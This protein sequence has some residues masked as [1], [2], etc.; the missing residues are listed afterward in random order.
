MSERET[1]DRR[2]G[3]QPEPAVLSSARWRA[4]TPR[5]PARR[6]SGCNGRFHPPVITSAAAASADS[7]STVVLYG[8][9]LCPYCQRLRRVMLRLREA[10]GDRLVY[11]FR[12]FPN[13]RAHPGGR[14]HRP[15]H[16]GGGEAGPFWEMHDWIYDSDDADRPRRGASNTRARSASTWRDSRRTSRARRPRA[17]VEEDLAGG[18]RNGVTGTPTL[19]IDGVRYDGAWDFYSMLE[20]LERPVAARL[21]RSARVFASLPASGGLVLLLS[22]PASRSCAPTRRSRGA[23]TALMYAPIQH[24]PSRA[25]SVLDRRG[26]VLGRAADALLPARRPRDPPRRHGRSAHRPTGGHVCRSSPPW[27]ASS[28]PPPSIWPSI[29][30]RARPGWSIPTATDIAFTLGILALLGDRSPPQLARLRRRPRRHRRHPLGAD[31]SRSSIRTTSTSPGWRP[32]RLA[33]ALLFTFNRWRVYATWPYVTVSIALWLALHAAGVDAA[34]T[35]VHPGPACLPTRPAPTASAFSAQAATALAAL[36]HAETEARAS[37]ATSRHSS[38]F[39]FGTGR[40]AT[41]RGERA[42]ALARRSVRARRRSLEHLRGA[43]RSSPFPPSAYRSPRSLTAR[44][45]SGPRR[46]GVRARAGQ[47]AWYSVAAWLAVR[48]RLA[49]CP[50]RCHADSVSSARPFFAAWGTRVALLIADRAF[51]GD[52]VAS[53]AKIGVL[54]GS[55][56]AGGLGSLILIIAS[57]RPAKSRDPQ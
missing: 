16:R 5:Q 53:L 27:A 32:A 4:T 51:P 57:R 6:R 18:Q 30:G 46:R 12:H 45:V 41:S 37:A 10:L 33:V 43:S 15:R 21:A 56:L 29:A 55:L 40:A 24:R 54:L 47:A 48:T 50:G 28:R 42:A 2:P 36:E 13:E 49:M 31:A 23:T 52:E 19:F 20:A 8:D 14:A 44:S 3:D 26:V 11:V 34:L 1:N 9:L 25:G 35:G 39:R 22:P 38:S 17:R 7:R